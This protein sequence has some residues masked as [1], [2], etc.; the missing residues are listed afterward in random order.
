MDLLTI[1]RKMDHN[2]YNSHQEFHDD[3]MLIIQN[4][5]QYWKPEDPLYSA[6]EKFQ[7]AFE[8][9]YALMNK[10]ITKLNSAD[11]Y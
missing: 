8:G 10:W 9:K 11:N 1:K 6:A 3:V 7:K 5:Q 2:Q 4:C